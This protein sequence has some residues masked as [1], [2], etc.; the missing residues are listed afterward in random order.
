MVSNIL[1]I[2]YKYI[3]FSFEKV[4]RPVNVDF[5]VLRKSFRHFVLVYFYFIMKI[6][7]DNI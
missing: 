7:E 2:K 6:N 1:G 3:F 4:N 5:Q